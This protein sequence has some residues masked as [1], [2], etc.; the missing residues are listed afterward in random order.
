MLHD[1]T[2]TS[3]AVKDE[4]IINWTWCLMWSAF[5]YFLL[6]Q[7]SV[8]EICFH[9]FQISSACS[10]NPPLAFLSLQFFLFSQKVA[11]FL[12]LVRKKSGSFEAGFSKGRGNVFCYLLNFLQG[13]FITPHEQNILQIT[14]HHFMSLYHCTTVF[15]LLQVS[16]K[17]I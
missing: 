6:P 5:M 9:S 15:L 13:F 3:V 7:I 16:E 14:I 2:K 1:K 10:G 8:L 11:C 12:H 17:M 4:D